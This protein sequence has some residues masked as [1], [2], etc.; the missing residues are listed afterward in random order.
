MFKHTVK[1]TD[2]NGIEHEKDIYFN[3]SMPELM[4]IER[5]VPGGYS[6]YL[7]RIAQEKDPN[8]IWATFAEII[9]LGYGEKSPDGERFI[10]QDG[11]GRKLVDHFKETPVFEEFMYELLT[12]SNL[13]VNMVNAMLPQKMI[14]SMQEKS[15]VTNA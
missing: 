14:Q 10:K 1:Y 3:I 11:N 13:A 9:D 4:N 12:D 15:G 7:T 6:S 5:S 8:D 2:Y